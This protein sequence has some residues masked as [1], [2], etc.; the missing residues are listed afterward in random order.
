MNKQY[1]V[2]KAQEI[3]KTKKDY[4]KSKAKTSPKTYEYLAN[5][6]FEDFSKQEELHSIP[7]SVKKLSAYS[8]ILN[9]VDCLPETYKKTDKYKLKISLNQTI[10]SICTDLGETYFLAKENAEREILKYKNAITNAQKHSK[11]KKLT[12]EEIRNK[13]LREEYL[14]K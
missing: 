13:R 5:C 2:K 4:Q 6:F 3:S 1:R 8:N 10:S 14:Y 9:I 11:G 12:K 7:S